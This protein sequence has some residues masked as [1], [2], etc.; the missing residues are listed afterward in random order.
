MKFRTLMFVTALATVTPL[1]ISV[2]LAAQAKQR[3]STK[4]HHYQFFD[5][6]TFGGPTSFINPPVNVNPE[7]SGQGVTAGG[8]ATSVALTPT[9]NPFDCGGLDGLIHKVFHAFEWQDEAVHDLGTLGTEHENCSNA[10]AVDENGDIV[11]GASENDT[12]DPV[13][14]FKELRAVRWQNGRIS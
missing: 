10:G 1:A 8:S 3:T 9:N 11:V 7:L 13:L 5:L 4:H 6:G 12:I 14:G 2:P